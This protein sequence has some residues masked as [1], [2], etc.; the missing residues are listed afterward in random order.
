M[1]FFY[2]SV[3]GAN[4][5]LTHFPVQEIAIVKKYLSAIELLY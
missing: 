2:P 3:L 1:L 5:F 4:K